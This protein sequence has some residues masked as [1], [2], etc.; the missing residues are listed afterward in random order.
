MF[1]E[2]CLEGNPLPQWEPTV[3]SEPLYLDFP[4]PVFTP[5]LIVINAH[6][7]QVCPEPTWYRSLSG[8]GRKQDLKKRDITQA[9]AQDSVAPHECGYQ[10]WLDG[11]EK[12]LLGC[13]SRLVK[14]K[15]MED[16]K[17]SRADAVSQR[18]PPATTKPGPHQHW[19]TAFLSYENAYREGGPGYSPNAAEALE[20]APEEDHEEEEDPEVIGIAGVEAGQGEVAA[21]KDTDDHVAK[22]LDLHQSNS[23]NPWTGEGR[24]LFEARPEGGFQVPQIG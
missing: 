18:R 22:K 5:H 24:D 19:Q 13:F 15:W 17:A 4:D 3:L 20:M 21:P 14:R 23:F 7:V 9:M 11:H 16:V 1:K 2:R 10:G 12:E 8:T 6:G